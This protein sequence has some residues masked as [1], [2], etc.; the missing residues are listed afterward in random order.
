[1]LPSHSRT[2]IRTI[3][4]LGMAPMVLMALLMWLVYDE[5]HGF[6]AVAMTSYCGI[7]L[8]F[9]GGIH[10][11]I[12]L[13]T[14][15]DAPKFHFIWGAVVAFLGWFSVLMHPAAGL[16]FLALLFVIC[17]FVDERTWERAGLS[18]W[19]T[20]RFHATVAAVGSCVAGAA[21]SV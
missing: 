5:L 19:L 10:W 7:V 17:Y 4:Y 11:G 20:L 6:V 8:S 21:G 18:E 16:P 14:G 3:F 9:L 1:M 12:G 13:R 2:F 15:L